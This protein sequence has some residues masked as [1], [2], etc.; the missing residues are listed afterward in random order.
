MP[1]NFTTGVFAT[2]E[3]HNSHSFSVS[4]SG[5]TASIQLRVPWADR[6]LIIDDLMYNDGKYP[7]ITDF[8]MPVKGCTCVPDGAKAATDGEGLVYDEAIITVS[9]DT[10]RETTET[11]IVSESLEPNLEFFTLPYQDFRWG[12]AVGD[13]LK[14]EEA[15]GKLLVGFDVV[16]TRYNLTTIPSTTTSEL[17]KVNSGS[18]T[19]AQLGLIMAAGTLLFASSSPSRKVTSTGDNKWTLA[20]KFSYRPQGWNTF[21]RAKTQAMTAMYIAGGSQYNNFVPGTLPIV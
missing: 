19:L 21:W 3:V 18:V 8:D 16:Q 7:Y 13:P 15:P 17:G 1:I 2:H 11:D 20:N 9:Y 14:P 6:Y 12:S 5:V 10:A 4:E